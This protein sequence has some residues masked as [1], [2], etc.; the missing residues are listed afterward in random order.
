MNKPFLV[1]WIT[2]EWA[3]KAI[4]MATT[5]IE[6][7][8]KFMNKWIEEYESMMPDIINPNKIKKFS[9]EKVADEFIE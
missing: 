5:P 4:V 1:S 2:D 6:A 7:W 3:D 9:V 8:E